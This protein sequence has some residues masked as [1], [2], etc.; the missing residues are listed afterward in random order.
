MAPSP[1]WK[2]LHLT[3]TAFFLT[4]L[5]WFN[6]PPLASTIASSLKLSAEQVKTLLI[7][8]VALTIP[9]RIAVGALVDR[10]GPRRVFTALLLL[11][12]FPCALCALATQFWQLV[13]GRLLVS[14]VGAGFVVGIRLVGEWF[15]RSQIGLAEG[16]YG[17]LGNFGMAAATFGLPLVA[18]A[19]GG[20]NG[21]RWAMALS[22]AACVAWALVFFRHIQDSPA[23]TTFE[24]PARARALQVSSRGDVVA[25]MLAQFPM[26]ACLG[27]IAWKLS[28]AGLLPGP[29]VYAAYALLAVLLVQQVRSVWRV[30][31]GVWTGRDSVPAGERYAFSQVAVLSLCYAVTFGGE[32]AVESMLPQY[33]EKTF[34]LSVA[35]AGAIGSGFAVASL[36]ARPMG[37]LLGDR[38]GRRRV[39]IVSIAGSVAGYAAI[40]AIDATW[41]LAAVAIVVVGT[42]L[43]LM[44]ANGAAFCIA[45]LIRKPL[46]GQ[47]AGLVGAYGNVGS[48]TFLTVLSLAGPTVFFVSM[49][50]TGGVALLCCLL[51]LREP[52]VQP[53]RQHAHVG[54]MQAPWLDPVAPE[55]EPA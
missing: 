33:L 17:G 7:C 6:F 55:I 26:V 9:A 25:L 37:G 43:F 14:C 22:G 54:P 15:D 20:T 35:L 34:G 32:L 50:V 46:T 2:M 39:M 45:P 42:G 41:S 24:R 49:A 12:A 53:S 30:N 36:V 47:I 29:L 44:A 3:W 27:I 51:L 21:W 1:R 8:N 10:F 18:L 16:L 52:E 5:V 40:A 19:I 31:G 28:G 13:V 48:V 23:G 38:V 11:V 4:F